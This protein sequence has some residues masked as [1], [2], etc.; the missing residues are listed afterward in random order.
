MIH[1]KPNF[2]A[3]SVQARRVRGGRPST[4]IAAALSLAGTLAALPADAATPALFL[5]QSSTWSV[6]PR[7]P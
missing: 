3:A 5:E 6:P 2:T 7:G 1:E 4:F